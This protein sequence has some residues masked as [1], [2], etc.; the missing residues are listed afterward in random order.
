MKIITLILCFNFV[1]L[2]HAQ[3]TWQAVPNITPN[4]NNQRFDDVFFLND[5]LGW[6]A[7]GYY[8]AVYKTT[9][10][11]L[12]WT[13]QLD[14]ANITGDF[15]FRNI[16]FLN[17]NIGFLGTLNSTFFKTVNGGDTW[18]TVNNITPNP[19][20]ICGLDVVGTSTIYGCGAYFEPAHIIKSTDSGATW[21]YTDM[22]AHAN[23][24]VEIKFL[25]E[26]IGYAG[27]RN[28]NGA[29]V[30]KTTDG[31][32]TWNEIYNSNTIGEY[33]WKLQILEANTDVIFGAVESNGTNPGK[34]IKTTNAGT[35]WTTLNAP[36]NKIQA[37]GF[38]NENTGWMGGH[39]TGFFETND[40]GQTWNNINIGS[41]LNRIFIVNPSLAYASGTSIYKFTSETLHT[42]DL[43]NY[44]N[45][46][47][48]S[49]KFHNNPVANILKFT[50]TFDSS[51]N[52]L[53][54]LYDIKGNF[55]KRMER[56][57]VAK[58]STKNYA[59]N[60]AN[61]ASGTYIIE[62]HNNLGR[63]SLQFIKE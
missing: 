5:N 26:T 33:V 8:A 52:L 14:E 51:D 29:V 6:A 50:I 60:V 39:N 45:T 36:D 24:L 27:G 63:F 3:P 15:Y 59:Y 47:P 13:K 25:N 56:D 19:N 49:I 20:G 38:I 44:I 4:I 23:A 53:I 48:L 7:N 43:G 46:N 12:T 57:I 54:R 37:V 58:S 35:S 34:L 42:T 31:G 11:G 22:S 40:G 18:E 10:G 62:F 32:N 1:V 21:S 41:N 2:A 16:T 55:I 28:D 17:E 9:D 30:L 61:L